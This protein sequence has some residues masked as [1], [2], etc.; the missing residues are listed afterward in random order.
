MKF[1]II[2]SG[3]CVCLPKPLCQCKVCAEARQK[4]GRY[5]R[6]GCSLYLEEA[7][8]LVDTPEDIA[9]A[10]NASDIR[11]VDRVLYTHRDPDHTLG[12]RIL[13]QLRLEWLDFYEK[14]PPN[15]PV[16]VCATP[17]VMEAING[18]GIGY[19][20]LLD[21]YVEMGLA[22]RKP[23]REPFSIGSL[24]ITAVPVGKSKSVSIFLFEENGRKAIY[25]PCDCKPFPMDAQFVGADL[26]IIG[27]TF[28]GDALKENR[29][30]GSDH[31]LRRELHSLE[32]VLEIKRTLS[33]PDVIV[34]HLEEAWGK[35]YDD[36]LAWEDRYPG[37]RFAY[38]G[39]AIDIDHEFP[40]RCSVGRI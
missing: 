18:I 19:G 17:E 33:I 8:L 38:D 30:I 3:G 21:Y 35:S 37:V 2:G 23:I 9:H 13:E 5:K 20:A 31:P 22:L 34:T 29:P 26:L 39:M 15:S 40:Q 4:G 27:N 36:Y 1:T 10:L 6:Y 16:E 32:D 7:S 11:A 28:V 12:M 25:A 24:T 14:I